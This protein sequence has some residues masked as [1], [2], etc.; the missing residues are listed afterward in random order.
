M[1]SLLCMFPTSSEWFCHCL[2][3]YLEFK[4]HLDNA[5]RHMVRFLGGPVWSQELDLIILMSPFQL[6]IFCI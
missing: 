1:N 6:G 3:C 4:K 5:L 2:K